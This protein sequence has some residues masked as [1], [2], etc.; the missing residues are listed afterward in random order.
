LLRSHL[1][2][3]GDGRMNARAGNPMVPNILKSNRQS[4]IFAE[5]AFFTW[6]MNSTQCCV[7]LPWTTL[8]QVFHFMDVL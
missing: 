5:Q 6:T 4:H 7:R 2:Q 3:F 1:V 8:C